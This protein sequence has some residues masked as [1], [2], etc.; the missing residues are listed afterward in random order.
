MTLFEFIITMSILGISVLGYILAYR[1]LRK[2][3]NELKKDKGNEE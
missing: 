3:L 1:D 2:Q